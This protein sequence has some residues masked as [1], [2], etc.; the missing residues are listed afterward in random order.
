MPQGPG[1]TSA[2]HVLWAQRIEKE[3]INARSASQFSVRA[4]VRADVPMKFKPGHSDP[5]EASGAGFKPE[6]MG[7]EPSGTMAKEFT[8]CMNQQTVGPRER[9]LFP[10]TCQQEIGWLMGQAGRA[11]GRSEPA[12][13]KAT[14]LGI[15]WCVRDGQGGPITTKTAEKA[16][17]HGAALIPDPYI[18]KK[19]P[20][21]KSKDGNVR[22]TL[23]V[24]PYATQVP[25]AQWPEE[26]P[27][28]V[29]SQ[30]SGSA[31]ASDSKGSKKRKQGRPR[32]AAEGKDEAVAALEQRAVSLPTLHSKQF[33][34]REAAVGKATK[35]I[36]QYLNKEGQFA[37]YRPLSNSDVATFADFYTK[38]WGVG[39]YS[40]AANKGM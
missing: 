36:R 15:G 5:R 23:A 10:E 8:R 19:L 31:S 24:P 4:A 34:K 9:Q 25:C 18:K 30:K 39:L 14:R 13:I 37:E 22:E 12:G 21:R 38:T 20:P 1:L 40:K 7:W 2:S 27:E 11:T 3:Q 33:E 6:A 35:N 17:E 16:G 29:Q 26:A 28:P 32:K